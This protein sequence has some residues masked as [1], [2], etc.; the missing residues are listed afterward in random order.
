MGILAGGSSAGGVCIPIMF[1]HLVPRIGLSWSFRAA[2]LIIIF[3]YA[4]SV[5]ISTPKLQR[6]PMKSPRD[7]LD[8]NGFRDVRYT[9]LAIA[10]I[11]GNFGLYVPF[12]YIGTFKLAGFLGSSYC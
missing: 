6:Q 1:S 9:V 10:S 7:L 11:I 8:F 3:C 4:V 5:L 12:Y 2:A